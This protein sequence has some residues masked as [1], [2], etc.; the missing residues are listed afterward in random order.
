M[1]PSC[2]GTRSKPSASRQ[3]SSVNVQLTVATDYDHFR[4]FRLGLV[5][6]GSIEARCR[7]SRRPSSALC[8]VAPFLKWTISTLRPC[9]S[10]KPLRPTI[11]EKPASPL[12]SISPR[13][14]SLNSCSCSCS[15]AQ[16]ATKSTGAK[17]LF[18]L[19]IVHLKPSSGVYVTGFY[20]KC[21]FDNWFPLFGMMRLLLFTAPSP[22]S[23]LCAHGG[24]ELQ[25][26]RLLMPRK[27]YG[28]RRGTWGRDQPIR[29]PDGHASVRATRQR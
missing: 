17:P 16:P 25:R 28:E 3:R 21:S 11:I 15:A 29:S 23:R 4:D 18:L 2:S 24:T 19:T 13:R 5:R 8:A 20:S 22:R 26:S 27:T 7:R 14:Q 1:S 12:G 10:A 6:A 9:L